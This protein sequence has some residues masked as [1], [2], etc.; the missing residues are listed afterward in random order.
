MKLMNIRNL[1]LLL[2]MSMLSIGCSE[3][4]KKKIEP[5]PEDKFVPAGVYLGVL[6]ITI[7]NTAQPLVLTN[8]LVYV[9]ET[10]DK[11]TIKIGVKNFSINDTDYG[12]IMMPA[13]CEK[14]KGGEYGLDGYMSELPIGTYTGSTFTLEG[15]LTEKGVLIFAVDGEIRKGEG[16]KKGVIINFEGSKTD[17]V[18]NNFIFGFES[19]R[20]INPFSPEGMRYSLPRV[21][22]AGMNWCSR[23][24]EV[25]RMMG[26]QYMKEFTVG[27][28]SD[29]FSGDLSAQVQTVA[30]RSG[31][32][33]IMLPQVYAG[34][35]YLGAFDDNMEHPHDKLLLGVPFATEP[36]SFKGVYKYKSGSKYYECP[37][38]TEPAN[39]VYVSGKKDTFKIDAALYEVKDWSESEILT[40]RNFYGSPKIVATAS[41]EGGESKNEFLEF[42][43][44]FRWKDDVEYDKNKLYRLVILA[45][46]SKDGLQYSGAPGSQLRIDQVRISTKQ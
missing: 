41:I 27:S 33:S 40:L 1:L 28:N 7:D 36:L 42:D 22:I 43:I 25:Y 4:S 9:D 30:T 3:D 19:W 37:N 13:V 44:S 18:I 17:M 16:E 26:I 14:T 46:A 31:L 23:D 10:S 21:T 5:E 15:S 34:Y 45:T 20:V 11:S 8:Q 29:R 2:T 12:D 6:K 38:P 35:F 32:N 39:V 24:A